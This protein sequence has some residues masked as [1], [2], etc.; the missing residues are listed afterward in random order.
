M[1]ETLRQD[2]ATIFM[3][4]NLLPDP[5]QASILRRPT[6][7]TLFLCSRQAGKSTTAA[8]LA[9][10]QALLEPGSLILL[11]S[12]TLRQSGEL[13]R[14]KVLRLFRPLNKTFPAKRLTATELELTSGSR[15][16]SLPE[17]EEGIR[18]FSNVRLL[19]IDEA[20]RVEDAVYRAVRPMLATAQGKLLALSTAF[21]QRG[22][23]WEAWDAAQ[24]TPGGN[25][26]T[27]QI[28]ADQCPRISPE[29]LAEERVELGEPW[30][31]QEYFCLFRSGVD[32]VFDPEAINRA[33]SDDVRP[34][35]E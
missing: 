4:A 29:F 7:N 28:T 33:M 23:F 20:A 14:D 19:I 10:R 6:A 26:R 15:I 3:A 11:V 2:P 8:A 25:W 17:S 12:P 5:W 18:G 13:F 32:C 35:F 1:R 24:K 16:I 27:L 22:W 9:L 31:L 21:G 30:F 34:L